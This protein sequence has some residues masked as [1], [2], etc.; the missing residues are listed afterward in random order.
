[1][2][3]RRVKNEQKNKRHYLN[4]SASIIIYSQSRLSNDIMVVYENYEKMLSVD[5]GMYESS[6]IRWK[7]HGPGIQ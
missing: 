2:P 5:K 7:T 6:R 4:N 3:Q 1:M